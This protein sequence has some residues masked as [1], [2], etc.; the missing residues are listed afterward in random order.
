MLLCRAKAVD[1]ILR[2]HTNSVVYCREA[3]VHFFYRDSA[4]LLP[5]LLYIAPAIIVEQESP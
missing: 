3:L 4:I 2:G 5:L 1:A